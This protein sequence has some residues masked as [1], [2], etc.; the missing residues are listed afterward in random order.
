MGQPS[1]KFKVG[2]VVWS[3]LISIGVLALGASIML[4]STKRARFDFRERE[5][6]RAAEEAARA[7]E[8]AATQPSSQPATQ[9]DAYVAAVQK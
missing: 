5:Q 7:A 1:R 3:V 9:P 8:S 6:M 2:S 4:P